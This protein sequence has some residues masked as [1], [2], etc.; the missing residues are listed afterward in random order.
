M[1]KITTDD[2]DFIFNT[3]DPEYEKKF[4]ELVKLYIEKTEIDISK[5]SDNNPDKK[6]WNDQLS[7][8]KYFYEY[9]N[10]ITVLPTRIKIALTD[11]R[12]RIQKFQRYVMYSNCWDIIGMTD[13]FV[14]LYKQRTTDELGSAKFKSFKKL[15]EI[16]KERVENTGINRW[17]S[18]LK[19]K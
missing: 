2:W 6:R 5:M 13:D 14:T 15:Y 3:E 18:R 10:W 19:K 12:K 9:E 16:Q 8:F 17:I 7:S 1:R 4:N 11:K